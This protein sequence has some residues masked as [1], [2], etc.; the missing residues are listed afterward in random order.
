MPRQLWADARRATPSMRQQSA[1]VRRMIGSVVRQS[2]RGGKASEAITRGVDNS[3]KNE[4]SGEI[5]SAAAGLAMTRFQKMKRE[6]QAAPVS[7]TVPPA[8]ELVATAPAH[9]L[10]AEVITN[11]YAEGRIAVEIGAQRNVDG[12]TNRDLLIEHEAH[13]DAGQGIGVAALDGAATRG[14]VF[15]LDLVVLQ[16][17]ASGRDDPHL[18]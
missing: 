11:G 12:R 17:E 3:G 7:F 1:R 9:A 2:L 13:A 18:L 14:G 6:R 5:A 16:P 8:G 15:N 10:A 4:T